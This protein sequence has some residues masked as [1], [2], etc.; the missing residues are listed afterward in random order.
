MIHLVLGG[1]R[2]GKSAFA[3]ALLDPQPTDAG[4]TGEHRI[5][6]LATGRAEPGDDDMVAR[7]GRHRDR[8]GAMWETVE[9]GAE[10]AEHL[11][12]L[13]PERPALVDALGTW[14]AAHPDLDADVAPVVEALRARTGL[15]V[16]VSD[17]VG[18]GVHPE[19]AVGRRFRD[20]LGEVN[21]AVAAVADE[22]TLVVA[23]LPVVVR[24][25][26]PEAT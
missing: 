2:S 24:S 5:A 1:A 23:G 11:C 20:V 13:S 22:V 3:E 16:V 9:V 14:V 12:G 17:E 8:R 10:L 15:T 4:G 25:T 18:L 21:Q 19:S 6:Y 26:R 7:I